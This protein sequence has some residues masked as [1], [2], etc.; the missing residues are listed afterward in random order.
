[1]ICRGRSFFTLQFL[2]RGLDVG[3]L[4]GLW[5]CDRQLTRSAV[6]RHRANGL[7]MAHALL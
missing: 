3:L 4:L 6:K 1:L 2:L 5:L 7:K